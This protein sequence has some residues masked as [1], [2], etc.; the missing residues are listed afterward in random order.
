MDFCNGGKKL[1]GGVQFFFEQRFHVTFSFIYGVTS[2]HW[3]QNYLLSS[4]HQP[5]S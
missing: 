5:M 3:L 4:G 2:N 1:V